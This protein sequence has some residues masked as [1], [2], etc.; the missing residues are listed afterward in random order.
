MEASSAAQERA[1]APIGV[2]EGDVA[3]HWD[4]RTGIIPA[5]PIQ[6]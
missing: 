1:N 4:A 6:Q 2:M 5:N 3:I